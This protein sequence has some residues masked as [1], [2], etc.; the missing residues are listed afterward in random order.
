M[1]AYVKTL[2]RNALDPMRG[3]KPGTALLTSVAGLYRTASC[4]VNHIHISAIITALGRVWPA[5]QRHSKSQQDQLQACHAAEALYHQSLK[6]LQPMLQ[7]MGARQISNILWASA[8]L[9]NDPDDFVQ[10]MVHTLADRFQQLTH[11]RK[12]KKAP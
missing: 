9:G 7:D 4:E 6:Q 10:G 3:F 1:T 11:A 8:N 12:H 5:A 2:E